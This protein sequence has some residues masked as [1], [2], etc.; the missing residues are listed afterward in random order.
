MG[1]TAITITC[2][3]ATMITM[4]TTLKLKITMLMMISICMEEMGDLFEIIYN[5]S[6]EKCNVPHHKVWEAF[7]N[8]LKTNIPSL[9]YIENEYIL[10]PHH[11]L[12]RHIEMIA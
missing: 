10:L 6:S 3:V 4:E 7:D 1:I 11:H 12:H 5:L 9:K 8:I 2:I